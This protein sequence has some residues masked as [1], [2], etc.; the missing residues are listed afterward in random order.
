MRE[1][2][3]QA[4]EALRAGKFKNMGECVEAFDTVTDET[5]AAAITTAYGYWLQMHNGVSEAEG[6]ELARRNID[7]GLSYMSRDC[8]LDIFRRSFARAEG[9]LGSAV[10]DEAT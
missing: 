2:V 6:M 7:I 3:V 1:E 8:A 5:D 10:R 9:F 4:C